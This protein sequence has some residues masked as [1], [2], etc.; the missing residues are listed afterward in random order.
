MKNQNKHINNEIIPAYSSGNKKT[1]SS[2]LL[3]DLGKN[4]HNDKNS[5]GSGSFTVY[6][7]EMINRNFKKTP[8]STKEIQ[9][10]QAVINIFS[11]LLI[12]CSVLLLSSQDAN[13]ARIKD[14]A[15]VVGVSNIQAIGYGLVTGLNNQGDNQNTSFTV[16]S[17]SN[18]LK[19]FGLTVPQTNP[20]VRNVAAV[21]L[22]ANIPAYAKRGS[23]IDI[24]VSSIGDAR[25]LQGG[26]L[27]MSPVSL[28]DGSIIGMA[29]GAVSVGGYDFDA[30]GSRI[31]KNYVTAGRVPSGLILEKDVDFTEDF[32]N[33]QI[34]RIALREPDFTTANNI[35]GAINGA[36]LGIAQVIDPGTV[37][38]Q[39]PTNIRNENMQSIANIERLQVQQDSPARVV[40]NE[41]TGTIVVGGNVEVSPSVIGH[42]NLEVTIQR[43]VVIPQPA[44]FVIRPPGPVETATI[45]A[46][47]ERNAVAPL[48]IPTGATVQNIVDALNALKV[49]P[50]DLI[51]IFQALKQSGALQA[52][53]VIQ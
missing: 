50:R 16:Q 3:N 18:M 31:S 34:I 36:N 49:S 37:E 35:A 41:R 12:I 48:T 5:F 47:E 10:P 30:L 1:F 26:I 38:V 13:S 46:E 20:K 9:I 25:S 19:R 39:L 17:V 23:K 40:I 22:T 7:F 45:T 29:Q 6:P 11:L 33:N 53:L 43:N 51:S 4:Y 27:I 44:P 15:N 14:I 52:E 8:A 24:Q 32:V 28:S 21:M 42:G 2:E